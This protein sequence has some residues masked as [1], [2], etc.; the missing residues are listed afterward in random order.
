MRQADFVVKYHTKGSRVVK[1]RAMLLKHKCCIIHTLLP[2]RS[3]VCRK[4]ECLEL[5]QHQ[6]ENAAGTQSTWWIGTGLYLHDSH[7]SFQ[8]CSGDRVFLCFSLNLLYNLGLVSFPTQLRSFLVNSTQV[9]LAR[10]AE[11]LL[12][13]PWI[14][15]SSS[16]PHWPNQELWGFNN[17]FKQFGKMLERPSSAG[18]ASVNLSN[19][20]NLKFILEWMCSWLSSLLLLS[21]S[22]QKAASAS[23]PFGSYKP[24]SCLQPEFLLCFNADVTT[25]SE[26]LTV[27]FFCLSPVVAITKAFVNYSCSVN[28]LTLLCI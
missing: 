27:G 25:L 1:T 11:S 6:I 28:K 3:S 22:H 17:P 21:L 2:K 10:S 24:V 8:P 12:C 20:L 7:F 19:S 16:N 9:K 23:H 13:F 26:A 18:A 5:E 4:A 15:L 14:V